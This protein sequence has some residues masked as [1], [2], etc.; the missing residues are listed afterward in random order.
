M[1][2]RL[3]TSPHD[4]LGITD[5]ACKNQSIMVSVQYGPFSSNIPIRSTTIEYKKLSQS[6]EEVI[7]EIESCAVKAELVS[8]SDMK[9][10]LSK[11]A[12][13]NDEL[14]SRSEKMF[15]ENQRLAGMISSSTRSSASLENLHGS[16]KPSGDKIGLG[17][18]SNER[19][20]AETNFTPKLERKKFKTIS[21]VKSSMGQPVEAQ[22]GET[23]KEAEPPIWKGRFCGL[24]YTA[25]EMP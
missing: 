15:N 21:F 23:M 20:S 13:E 5:S 4:P 7:A 22:T 3:A 24:E 2:K 17:Y 10:T 9:A 8:S 19:S 11:L 1:V 25:P 6:F 16:M 18:D 12:A 14:R